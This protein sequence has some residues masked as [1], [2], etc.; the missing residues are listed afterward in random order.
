[1][2]HTL[3]VTGILPSLPAR[4]GDPCP[5]LTPVAEDGPFI[6]CVLRRPN[7]PSVCNEKACGLAGSSRAPRW[8]LGKRSSEERNYRPCSPPKSRPVSPSIS[9]ADHQPGTTEKDSKN[10]KHGEIVSQPDRDSA[11]NHFQA[12]YIQSFII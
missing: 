6:G 1:M 2:P 11:W 4:T 10:G 5:P 12:S 9:P 8:S 3:N 7:E